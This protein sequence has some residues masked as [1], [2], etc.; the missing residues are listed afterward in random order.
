[1]RVRL[2][3][4]ALLV[5]F[6][7]ASSG[8]A[9]TVIEAW[10]SPFG[11]MRAVA[12]NSSDGS[13]WVA[14]GASVMHIA[15][16]GGI[17]SQTDFMWLPY[18][19]SVNQ[20]DG[21]CWVAGVHHDWLSYSE[22]WTSRFFVVHLAADGTV[23]LVD[24]GFVCPRS[25]S[26]NPTDAS[27]WVADDR[28]PD[29]SAV[30]H[31]AADGSRLSVTA[32][33][34]YPTSV[35]VNPTDG[36]CWV[37]DPGADAVVHLSTTGAELWRGEGIWGAALVCVNPSDGSCWVACPGFSPYIVHL[38]ASGEELFRAGGLLGPTSLSADPTDGSCWVSDGSTVLHLAVDCTELLR[39]W[40]LDGLRAVSAN[41]VDGSC[42]LVDGSYDLVVHLRSDGEVLLAT[43]WFSVPISVSV[44]AG[45]GSCWV[46]DSEADIVARLGWD[47]IVFVFGFTRPR[48]VSADSADGSCW[49]SDGDWGIGQIVHLASDGTVLWLGEGFSNAESVSVNPA[50]GSCWVADTSNDRVVH[51]AAS[52]DEI[53]NGEFNHP[54]WVS[55]NPADGTCWV[56][57]EE[58]THLTASGA[59]IWNGPYNWPWCSSV[60]PTDGSCWIVEQQEVVHLSDRG[61]ELWRRGGFY[62]LTS[63]SVD[64]VDGSCW[65]ADTP[66]VVHL[67]ADGTELWRGS[68]FYGPSSVC[69]D[70]YDG[71]CW[72]ADSSV[73]Q[74]TL[75]VPICSSFSDVNCHH[76][77]LDEINGCADAD[78]VHGYDDGTYR[79][80]LPVSRD[81]MAVYISRALAGGDANVPDVGCSSPPFT[82]V[83]CDHWARNY[84]QYAVNQGVVEGYLEGDYK[85]DLEVTRDQMAVYIARSLVAP[86]G[87]AALA[88]Y[89]P[90]DPRN[91]PDVP[92]TF[93]AYRHVEYC[94]ENGV[95]SGYE[96]GYY[97]PEIVV[98]RDQMAVYIARAFELLL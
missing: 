97:H 25:L 21:S 67:A 69:V 57:A 58:L 30:V 48:S 86:S 9:E 1:M 83:D 36:S 35:S 8:F 50:D 31:L 81:Q 80:T 20:S 77:A 64:P 61:A 11:N 40:G 91:F 39:L 22:E 87:E 4:V 96:D 90:P 29:S 88:D 92:D 3:V 55:V 75:L 73:G 68:W 2:C 54:Y 60:N 43:G 33:F 15:A 10:R 53:W 70:P 52:G 82:D 41:P 26:V 28:Y 62:S 56:C 72:V 89:V 5:C 7:G 19:I 63:L 13:C 32:G 34:L 76:W 85:P 12:V 18:A 42:W 95:V 66:Q 84:I 98:T 49:V 23:L 65:V 17:L 74:V 93:W 59:V 47:E 24:E 37:A 6:L 27:C 44:D 16:D 51:L 79:P 45:D 71:S 38:A 78:V 94:V 14:A 46:G